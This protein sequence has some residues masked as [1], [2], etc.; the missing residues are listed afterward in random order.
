MYYKLTDGCKFIL[1][2]HVDDYIMGYEDE[3]YFEA[4]IAHFQE[5]IQMT[6]KREIDFMLQIK[7]EWTDSSVSLSQNRQIESLKKK[8]NACDSK[9]VFTTPMETKLKLAMGDANNLPDVPYRESGVC[10]L[11]FIARYT[12][13]DIL[14]VVTLLCR[15]L[16]NYTEVHWKAA[17]RVLCYTASTTY[18]VLFYTP[19]VKAPALELY[20][21][22]D[23]GS[24]QIDGRSTTAVWQSCY[25]VYREANK[26]CSLYK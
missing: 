1:S 6:C 15:F 11:L 7:L 14:F 23:W 19:N 9:R 10:S 22:S 25:L 24:D 13:P 12:R 5:T 3:K 8:F 17:T 16:T 18:R 20:T 4:F 21:D 26:C 2:V